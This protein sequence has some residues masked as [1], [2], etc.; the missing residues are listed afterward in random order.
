MCCR[1]LQFLRRNTCA[2]ASLLL[3]PHLTCYCFSGMEAVC[4]VE[5]MPSLLPNR[6][7]VRKHMKAV[8]EAGFCRSG[9]VARCRRLGTYNRA[10]FSSFE[11]EQS[12]GSW[13]ACTEVAVYFACCLRE[14]MGR[15]A[16]SEHLEVSL[17][18]Q[19]RLHREAK[20]TWSFWLAAR[21]FAVN[22]HL[23]LKSHPHHTTVLWPSWPL[24]WARTR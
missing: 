23:N 11:S 21:S 5:T 22:N 20:R 14:N 9:L 17:T 4:L 6:A 2:F 1:R 3:H 18:R 24:V 19:A 15:A 7:V 16:S 13:S 12:C 10:C 8:A